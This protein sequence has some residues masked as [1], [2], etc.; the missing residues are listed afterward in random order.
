M[1]INKKI[2]DGC[3]EIWNV[4]SRIQIDISLVCCISNWT[5]EDKF[6]ISAHPCIIL[7]FFEIF[8]AS[9]SQI[10][11]FLHNGQRTTTTTDTFLHNPSDTFLYKVNL[12]LRTLPVIWENVTEAAEATNRVFQRFCVIFSPSGRKLENWKLF[13]TIKNV[14]VT[15]ILRANTDTWIIR[16][17]LR[18]PLASVLTR[19]HCTYKRPV[20]K[21]VL[22]L[23]YAPLRWTAHEISPNSF[24][25]ILSISRKL[26]SI[27]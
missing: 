11:M 19:F 15:F 7:Y 24:Y 13:V 17:L 2:I 16:K 6:H 4:S 18:V 1:F 9:S 5:L 10:S 21:A 25:E 27:K 20:P 8:I 23:Q 12:I 3:L 14:S 26:F 22:I